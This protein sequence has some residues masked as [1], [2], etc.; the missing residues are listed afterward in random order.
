ML[1]VLCAGGDRPHPRAQ[2]KLTTAARPR[3][4]CQR[5]PQ[6]PERVRSSRR[7]STRFGATAPYAQPIEP[8]L[9]PKLR[10]YFADFPYSHCSKTRG[11]KPRRPDAVMSTTRGE[12]RSFHRIFK[13]RPQGTGHRQKCGA[14]PTREPY[15]RLTRF[16]G[17][18]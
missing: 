12:N 10:I 17:P 7:R 13:G 8:I 3:A 1:A 16:H 5:P 6:S 4:P 2:S 9:F 14:F 11:F 18:V 15:L